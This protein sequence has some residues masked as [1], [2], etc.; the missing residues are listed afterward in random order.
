[1]RSTGLTHQKASFNKF[2]LK[3]LGPAVNA[4]K[5]AAS[6]VLSALTKQP[7]NFAFGLFLVNDYQ[8]RILDFKDCPGVDKVMK[9]CCQFDAF[10]MYRLCG[11]KLSPEDL[12]AL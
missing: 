12:E 4:G 5:A 2:Y 11:L 9:E 6:A 7:F 1:V 10:D 3:Y 8:R